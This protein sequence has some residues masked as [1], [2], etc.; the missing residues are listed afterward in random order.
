MQIITSFLRCCSYSL[1]IEFQQQVIDAYESHG[2]SA[3][4]EL[5]E[6][7]RLLD[8]LKKQIRDASSN[9]LPTKA[10]PLPHTRRPQPNVPDREKRQSSM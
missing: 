4:D 9:E 7:Q 8:Q 5:K 10:L 6:A 2:P 3:Q 1:A